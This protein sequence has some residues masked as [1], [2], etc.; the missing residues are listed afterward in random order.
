MLLLQTDYLTVDAHKG[1]LSEI[2]KRWHELRILFTIQCNGKLRRSY[3]T[4]TVRKEE[5]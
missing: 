4:L 3:L 5:E 1:H 2:D